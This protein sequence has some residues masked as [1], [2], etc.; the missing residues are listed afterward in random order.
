MKKLIIAAVVLISLSATSQTTVSFI[1]EIDDQIVG[2]V[3]PS[4]EYHLVVRIWDDVRE[5]Y[6]CGTFNVYQSVSSKT[7]NVVFSPCAPV[8]SQPRYYVRMW[9]ERVNSTHTYQYGSGQDDAG[10]FS[11]QELLNGID[12]LTLTITN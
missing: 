5:D 3:S 12:D 4:D 10:L 6:I 1:V 8:D 11:G 7:F 2:N 9:G